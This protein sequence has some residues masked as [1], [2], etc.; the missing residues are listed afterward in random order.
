MNEWMNVQ[1][2][3]YSSI[4]HLSIIYSSII[5]WRTFDLG[6]LC[7]IKIIS[8]AFYCDTLNIYIFIEKK[9]KMFNLLVNSH[10]FPN[11][12]WTILLHL[13]CNYIWP[14]YFQYSGQF[15]P[16]NEFFNAKLSFQDIPYSNRIGFGAINQFS[17]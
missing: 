17:I 8:F 14:E 11:E 1:Y 10:L 9:K 6:Y 5:M 16:L 15:V 13:L 2:V 4:T 3:L 12:K 7:R